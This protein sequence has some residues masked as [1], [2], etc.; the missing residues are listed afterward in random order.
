[1]AATDEAPASTGVGV[2]GW[3]GFIIVNIAVW[4]I[5]LVSSVVSWAGG[6]VVTMVY[7]GVL[8]GIAFCLRRYDARFAAFEN[9]LWV[10]SC[11]CLFI[12]G[13]YL[14][15][16][17]IPGN[18]A[19]VLDHPESPTGVPHNSDFTAL[20]PANS[21]DELRHWAEDFH[22]AAQSAPSFAMYGDYI[23][24]RGL[25]DDGQDQRAEILL[26]SNESSIVR[27]MPELQEP[28]SLVVFGS[29]LYFLASG[30]AG[31]VGSDLWLINTTGAAKATAVLVKSFGMGYRLHSLDS[32]DGRLYMKAEYTCPTTFVRTVLWTDGTAE[33]LTNLLGSD[34]CP[35]PGGSTDPFEPAP[36]SVFDDVSDL[37][38]RNQLW[39]LVFLSCVPMLTSAGLVLWKFR[40]PGMFF[41]LYCGFAVL[42]VTLFFIG[43]IERDAVE[44]FMKTFLT[45]YSA[46]ALLAFTLTCLLREALPDLLESMQDWVIAL[47]SLLL[48]VMIHIDLEVPSTDTAWPWVVYALTIPP[49]M[50]IS[51]S[52]G[53][54]MPLV[55]GSLS[56][57]I[58]AW[59]ISREIVRAI[60]GDNLSEV[61][62]LVLLAI[63]ALQ[64]IA[65]IVGAIFYAKHRE[66]IGD[67][68]RGSLRRCMGRQKPLM[69]VEM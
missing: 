55:L 42:V 13:V 26:R 24:F 11:W 44:V 63:L 3:L 62:M 5:I 47:T 23:F 56:T 19:A 38:P 58:V 51:V 37:P 41:N 33:G 60:Y 40:M 16:N 35:T 46:G 69:P 27:V 36:P 25:P 6:F 4:G 7:T 49:W 53:H 48:F 21:S 15:I 66:A 39:G 32:I 29:A 59:K 8:V 17:V 1:M 43:T 30:Q 61:P 45:I 65:I 34:Y 67:V 52:V 2:L 28:R 64:G 31:K 68:V 54:M 14:S 50:V 22:W 20:L 9:L 12:L 18:S 10:L 57:F